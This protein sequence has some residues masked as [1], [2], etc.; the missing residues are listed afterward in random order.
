MQR[1]FVVYMASPEAHLY[2]SISEENKKSS[3]PETTHGPLDLSMAISSITSAGK[4]YSES[5]LPPSMPTAY[6]RW[7]PELA[8]VAPHDP[9]TYFPMV[10]YK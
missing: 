6:K 5:K 7:K 9:T 8:P 4:V 1:T 2:S 3:V 10:L